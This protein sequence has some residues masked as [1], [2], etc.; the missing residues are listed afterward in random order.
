MRGENMK[1]NLLTLILIGFSLWLFA[2]EAG[3][4][5]SGSFTL[6]DSQNYQPVYINSDGGWTDIGQIYSDEIARIDS[7]LPGTLRKWRIKTTYI[8]ESSQGQSTLQIRLEQN[9]KPDSVFTLPWTEGGSRWQ[10]NNSNWFIPYS[11]DGSLIDRNATL[12]VRLIA[13]PR[14]ST[15]G[16]V[17]KI[18]LEAWDFTDASILP[19]ETAPSIRMAFSSPKSLMNPVP[20][21][22]ARSEVSESADR[23]RALAFSLEF[24]EYTLEG[25][26]PGFYKSLDDKIH[27]LK[28]GLIE[29]KYRIAPPAADLSAYTIRDYT[30]SYRYHLYSYDEY[31]DLFPEWA[32]P[33]RKWVPD[34]NCYLFLGTE[35]KPGQRDFMKDQNLVF[36]VRFNEGEWK[37]TGIPE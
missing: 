11:E 6:Y 1:K 26:L 3:G 22:A 10:E 13:P 18:K 14:S 32:D 5:L 2:E 24:I 15:P 27:Q 23:E 9:N 37:I 31:I 36:M 35:L 17:Y 19:G 34:E 12:A 21:R 28:T 33:R 8:D 25:N 7:P 30:N 4:T 20:D 29:S 16:K